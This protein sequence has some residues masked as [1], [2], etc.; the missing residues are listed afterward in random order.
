VAASLNVLTAVSARNSA[1]LSAISGKLIGTG[2]AAFG[3][4]KGLSAPTKAGAEFQS[5]LEDIRQKSGI[6]AP[7]LKALGLSLRSIAAATNQLPSNIVKTFDAL[8]GK[9]LGGKTD[10]E[11]ID[12]ALKMLPT[13]NKVASAYRASSGDVMSAGQA[14]FA[15]LKVPADQIIFA[16]DAMARSGKEG[17]FELKD[18][19]REFP[20]L[21][22]S[23]QALKMS[24]VDGVAKL[25]AALQIAR[26]GASDGSEAATNTANLMQKVISP[27]RQ[28]SLRSWAL[29]FAAN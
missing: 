17:A 23:A 22:A 19:A 9:G 15:N 5:M 12:A 8:L 29:I 27:E 4:V 3:L 16:F 7:E 13:I 2:E 11:N 28:R 18:M 1:R 6:A 25:A 24:G 26:K 21:T 14:A 20:S 10:A